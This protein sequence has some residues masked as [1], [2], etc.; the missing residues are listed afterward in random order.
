MFLIITVILHIAA[1]LTMVV[2]GLTIL[3]RLKSTKRE[4]FVMFLFFSFIYIAGEMFEIMATTVDGGMI[5]RRIVAFGGQLAAPMF[6][7]FTQQ[8]C[9]KRLPKLLNVAVFIG[10][11]I[12]IVL[13]WTSNFHAL[14]YASVYL[15]PD[16]YQCPGGRADGLL[17]W[18]VTYGPL[19]F[20][21][22]LAPLASMAMSVALLIR[23]ILYSN[24]EQRKRLSIL[25][26]CAII[27]GISAVLPLLV[28][29]LIGKYISLFLA[30]SA[31]VAVYFGLFKFDLLENEEAIHSQELMREM[32]GNIS[33]DLKT[34]LTVMSVNIERL[35][36]AAPGD[37]NYARDI[38]IAYNKNL[39]LQRLIQNLIEVTRMQAANN[40][41]LYQPV[42]FPLNRLLSDIQMQ[43]SD[44]LESLGLSL[45]VTGPSGDVL[46][47]SDPT[48]IWS[49]FDNIIYNAA[50]Y[51]ESGGIT[52]TTELGDD[53]LTIRVSDT[54]CGIAP[55]HLPQI[56]D[57]F[58]QT[59]AERGARVDERGL[60]LYIVK[61]IMEGCGGSVQMESEV[62]LGT[63][64][65][66]TFKK[67]KKSEE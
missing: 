16:I 12:V 2:M 20:L 42:W 30:A 61:S 45:D 60:G 58:Y 54:G 7:M 28:G 5:G 65:I 25:L 33:H 38:R 55:E 19:I 32:I 39:D 21:V 4:L 52:V 22:L 46:L 43:Y 34:P 56:F 50:R 29:A 24:V 1:L 51:T 10:A 37:P 66:L 53:T 15:C 44:Y 18:G 26:G 64:I 6:L 48:K 36:H 57:R 17:V 47:Y 67:K 59:T 27:P 35:L 13:V 40:K 62:G 14:I 49:V 41:D 23:K 3:T 8:Y 31:S 63:S 9:E 11:A